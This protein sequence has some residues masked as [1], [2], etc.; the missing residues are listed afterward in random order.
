LEKSDEF[1]RGPLLLDRVP[2]G[3][4]FSAW[5]DLDWVRWRLARMAEQRLVSPFSR[6][7]EELYREL[8]RREHELLD[9]QT[10]DLA[11]EPEREGQTLDASAGMRHL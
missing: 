10:I 4:Q 8:A 7:E 1:F 11:R 5:N 9:G 6:S 2:D 3:D